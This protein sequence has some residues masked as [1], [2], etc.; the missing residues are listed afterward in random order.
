MTRDAGHVDPKVQEMRDAWALPEALMGGTRRMR[1]ERDSWL[2]QHLAEDVKAWE[3]RTE[4]AY[5]HDAY[6]DTVSRLA[7]QPFARALEIKREAEEAELDAR[8]AALV[9]DADR[10]GTALHEFE[11]QSFHDAIHFGMSLTLVDMPART[12]LANAGRDADPNTRPYYVRIAPPDILGYRW[13]RTE[14]GARRLR[15]FRYREVVEVDEGDYGTHRVALAVVWD[16]PGSGQKATVSRHPMAIDPNNQHTG[17]RGKVPPEWLKPVPTDAD[18]IPL[19]VQYFNRKDYLVA[20]PALESLAWLNLQHFRSTA[21][22]GYI[23]DVARV[24]L[25]VRKAA[26]DEDVGKPLAI[27]ARRVVDVEDDG[28]LRYVEIEG[29]SIEAGEKNLEA[30]EKR[31]EVL[32]MRP[33]LE[34][35]GMATATSANLNAASDQSDLLAWI[36]CAE[37]AARQR[38][39]WAH[40]WLGVEMDEAVKVDISS[41]FL[42]AGDPVEKGKLIATMMVAGDIS[43][44]TGISELKRI[45]LLGEGVD[46]DAVLDELQQ[47]QPDLPSAAA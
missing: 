29:A 7:A 24:P 12:T 32:G 4:H 15:Q 21:S 6:A 11:K 18:E 22:Q 17:A 47:E 39:E 5:L 16:A 40:F 30:I 13:E 2:P 23:L 42:A 41:D 45:G 9:R 8:I 33:M 25:L 43:R 20:E 36:R 38:L 44:R 14:T 46:V 34:R 19:V 35:S 1:K 10:R 28:D 31:M 27:G 37:I 26:K 3:E